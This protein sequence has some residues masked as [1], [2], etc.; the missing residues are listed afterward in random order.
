MG[1]SMQAPS[2]PSAARAAQPHSSGIY[3][4]FWVYCA[5]VVRCI[6]LY[7]ANSTAWARL[8]CEAEAVKVALSGRA[9]AH[10]Q[11]MVPG[12]PVTRVRLSQDDLQEATWHLRPRLWAPL[13]RMGQRACVQWRMRW[14]GHWRDQRGGS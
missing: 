1:F 2:M 11:L 13:A 10:V 6:S 4:A 12:A 7:R 3:S 14:A 8:L 9:T 5:P